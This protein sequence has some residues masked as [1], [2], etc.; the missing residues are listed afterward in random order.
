MQSLA[1]PSCPPRSPPI[2]ACGAF[3]KIP[4]HSSPSLSPEN[5]PSSEQTACPPVE[6][7]HLHGISASNKA[8]NGSSRRRQD[9]WVITEHGRQ[10]EHR[11][12]HRRTKPPRPGCRSAGCFTGPGSGQDQAPFPVG[13]GHP[14]P[15][16]LPAAGLEQTPASSGPPQPQLPPHAAGPLGAWSLGR[17]RCWGPPG[18]RR[19]PLQPWW[20]ER[21]NTE[22][23]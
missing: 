4:E 21:K 6:H 5:P 23:V 19:S 2:P 18:P 12:G 15:P 20:G 22:H 10:H 7:R 16:F 3:G 13:E 17:T 1:H 8:A 9:P 14:E 11:S